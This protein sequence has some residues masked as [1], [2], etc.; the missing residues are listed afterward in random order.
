MSEEKDVKIEI[1]KSGDKYFRKLIWGKTMYEADGKT[2]KK[3][4]K[5]KNEKLRSRNLKDLIMLKD[6]EYND[7][8]WDGGEIYDTYSGKTYSC[9]MKLEKGKLNIRGYIGIS[10]LGRTALGK[11]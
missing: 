6:F 7:G 9:T 2:S 10:L 4:V 3:D 1:Y 11:S 5:N 8:V